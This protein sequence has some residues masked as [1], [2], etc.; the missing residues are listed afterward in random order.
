MKI[1]S[2]EGVEKGCNVGINTK[3]M[4]ALLAFY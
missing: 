2:G 4:Q 1:G 3:I